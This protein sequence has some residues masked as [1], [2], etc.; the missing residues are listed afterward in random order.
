[1]V[2]ARPPDDGSALVRRTITADGVSE[3]RFTDPDEA[4]AAIGYG[5]GAVDLAVRAGL[6]ERPAGG[7]VC[8]VPRPFD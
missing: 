2:D 8:F 6:I 5:V 4:F 1:M 3:E 7:P